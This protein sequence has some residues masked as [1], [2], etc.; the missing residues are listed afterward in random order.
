MLTIEQIRVLHEQASTGQSGSKALFKQPGD[1]KF[2]AN[3]EWS[4]GKLTPETRGVFIGRQGTPKRSRK[5]RTVIQAN[6]SR[7]YVPW[8]PDEVQ[9]YQ[10]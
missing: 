2:F 1:I 8:N 10:A 4:F 6:G 3:G 5:G 7:H 9:A